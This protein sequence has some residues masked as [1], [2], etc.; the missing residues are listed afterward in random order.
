MTGCHQVI[1]VA[2]R[3]G[4][5]EGIRCGLEEVTDSSNWK[6]PVKASEGLDSGFCG[7]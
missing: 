6:G 7:W 4:W 2:H 3:G 1:G 5:G